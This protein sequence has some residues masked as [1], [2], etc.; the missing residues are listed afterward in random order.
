MESYSILMTMK[1]YTATEVR[2]DIYP[3]ILGDI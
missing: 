3:I 2:K 1:T